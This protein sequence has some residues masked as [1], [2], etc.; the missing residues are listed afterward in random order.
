[1]AEHIRRSSE[2]LRQLSISKANPRSSFN[3][4]NIKDQSYKKINNLS[5]N[6]LS[7]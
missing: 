2:K 7:Y 6:K 1:M 3:E 5:S 4:E